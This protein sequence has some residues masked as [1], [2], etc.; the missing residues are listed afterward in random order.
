MGEGSACLDRVRPPG[1]ICQNA[2]RKGGRDQVEARDLPLAKTA[3][4]SPDSS[5]RLGY[6]FELLASLRMMG[7]SDLEVGIGTVT[8]PCS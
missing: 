2:M 1:P 4:L 5:R 7:M 3:R 6:Q 8:M